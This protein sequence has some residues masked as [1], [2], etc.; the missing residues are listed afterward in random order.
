MAR[1]WDAKMGSYFC[2]DPKPDGCA[3]TFELFGC[4]FDAGATLALGF[5]PGGPMGFVARAAG[6]EDWP[7]VP[8]DPAMVVHLPDG[9]VFRRWSGDRRWAERA[10]V[11][12]SASLDFWRW[13]ERTADQLWRF[14]VPCPPFS[15]Q[16]GRDLG[17]LA[18]HAA[19]WV[20]RDPSQALRLTPEIRRTVGHHLR[21][22]SARLLISAQATSGSVNALYG[23]AALDLH[24]S[25]KGAGS[26]EWVGRRLLVPLRRARDAPLSVT[27]PGT[28]GP[29]ET[30][31]R[32]YVHR[33]LQWRSRSLSL[34]RT[35][36]QSSSRNRRVCDSSC[37]A[38]RRF[39]KTAE[40]HDPGSPRGEAQTRAE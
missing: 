40:S 33:W 36:H 1:R 19:H 11:L 35:I 6:V 13:Q 22:T 12:G 4:R 21:G 26:R 25:S 2:A 24:E 29:D 15:S 32:K 18:G 28:R 20:I 34:Y 17:K 16:S 5:T 27:A 14:A 3:G 37:Q 7:I 23:A 30:N 31:G 10:E 8:A 9:A 39:S 38:R